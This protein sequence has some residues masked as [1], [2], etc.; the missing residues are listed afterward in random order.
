MIRKTVKHYKRYVRTFPGDKFRKDEHR[1][2]VLKETFWLLFIPIY[3]RQ[4][5]VATSI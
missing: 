5:I 1:E 3:S 2:Q 4:T